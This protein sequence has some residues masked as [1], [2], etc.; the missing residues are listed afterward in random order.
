MTYMV[1]LAC[2]DT[3]DVT[4]TVCRDTDRLE[5]AIKILADGAIVSTQA[6][7]KL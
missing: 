5:N 2:V 6:S 1:D 7:I 4:N 3:N